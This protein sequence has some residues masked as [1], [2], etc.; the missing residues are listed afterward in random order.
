MTM[1]TDLTRRDFLSACGVL[2]ASLA[3]CTGSGRAIRTATSFL[4]DP[5]FSDYEGTLRA[6]IETVLPPAFPIDTNEVERRFLR[7][8]PL[9]EERR[10]LGFQKTLVYF[11]ALDLAPHVAAPLLA[12]ERIALDVPERMT[13]REFDALCDAKTRR[14]TAAAEAFFGRFGRAAHFAALAPEARVAW[15]RLWSASEFTVKREFARAVRNLVNI[16]AY[17]ADGVWP[18]IGYDGTLIGRPERTS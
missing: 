9:E 13:E 4:A 11:D 15:L 8:F 2:A 16:S 12:E 10:F 6:L 17:S 3:A 18:S 14:E 1:S 7:M 5:A